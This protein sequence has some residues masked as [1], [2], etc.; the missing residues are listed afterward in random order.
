MKIR[1]MKDKAQR[2]LN[3]KYEEILI[4]FYKYIS[5]YA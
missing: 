2:Q 3:L 4:I 1:Y 5:I